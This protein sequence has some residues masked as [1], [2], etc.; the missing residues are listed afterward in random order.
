MRSLIPTFALDM[1]SYK[2]RCTSSDPAS[3]VEDLTVAA[4][5]GRNVMVAVGHEALEADPSRIAELVW[6]V[7][8]GVIKDHLVAEVMLYAYRRTRFK[9][10][11]FKPYL[12]ASIPSGASEAEKRIAVDTYK[13]MASGEKVFLAE[14]L[15][16]AAWGADLLQL[17]SKSH[18]LLLMG[19]GNSTLGIISDGTITHSR[20]IPFAGNWLDIHIQRHLYDRLGWLLNPLACRQI[21]H[22]LGSLD[23]SRSAEEWRGTVADTQGGIRPVVVGAEVRVALEQGLQFIVGELRWF[24]KTLPPGT[25]ETA[26]RDGILLAGGSAYLPGIAGWLAARLEMKVR[27]AQEPDHLVI[28]GMAEVLRRSPKF[29]REKVVLVTKKS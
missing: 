1:G 12:I 22:Q 28:F 16:A 11:L 20:R 23:D 26:I 4:I 14:D 7:E 5:D 8:E 25:L 10:A 6:P 3:L 21:K 13:R 17:D 27:I 19:A 2:I 9:R 29:F 18:L 15:D 24:L